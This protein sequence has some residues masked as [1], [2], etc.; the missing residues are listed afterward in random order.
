MGCLIP[1]AARV[2]LLAAALAAVS[3]CV[4]G[5]VS[6]SDED[7]PLLCPVRVSGE[8]DLLPDTD[9]SHALSLSTNDDMIGIDIFS[10]ELF[11][12]F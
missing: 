8:G 4:A 7:L 11:V 9:A 5:R 3:V 1:G 6:V 12:M 2:G 10:S